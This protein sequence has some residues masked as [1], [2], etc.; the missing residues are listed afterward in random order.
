MDRSRHEQKPWLRTLQNAK[1]RSKKLEVPF[2]LT[3]ESVC[4]LYEESDGICPVLGVPMRVGGDL[5]FVPSLD[6][7]KPELGYVL[8]NVRLIS[9]R[10]NSLRADATA[11]ELFLVYQD[12]RTLSGA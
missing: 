3:Q 10:A 6:R 2:S 1:S 5:Q 12:A 7:I 8:G 11:D 9:Y 4:S